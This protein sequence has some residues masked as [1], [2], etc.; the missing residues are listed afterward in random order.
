MLSRHAGLE[1]E[2]E[3]AQETLRAAIDKIATVGDSFQGTVDAHI[4]PSHR[5]LSD[6]TGSFAASAGRLASFI[7]DGLDPVT[8][9]LTAFDQTLSRLEGTVDAIRD[10][11]QV[12][13]E[14]EELSASLS[15]AAGVAKAIADLPDQIR[16]ILEELVAAQH[17]EINSRGNLLTWIRGRPKV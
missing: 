10:F 12:R 17:H 9:R 1:R 6:A 8:Q 14:V 11:S 15:Q 13:E 7:E 2:I 16:N 3:P 5:A 4:A